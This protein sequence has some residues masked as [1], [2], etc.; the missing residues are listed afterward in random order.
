MSPFF[1]LPPYYYAE[2]FNYS[3]VIL[4][5]FLAFHLSRLSNDRLIRGNAGSPMPTTVLAILLILFFGFR[6]LHFMFGDMMNYWRDFSKRAHESAL[7]EGVFS[8]RDA[9]WIILGDLCRLLFAKASLKAQFGAVTFITALIQVGFTAWGCI[10]LDREHAYI[11]FLFA[12]SSMSYYAYA[13]NGMR[14]GLGCGILFL[15][16]SYINTDKKGRIKAVLLCLLAYSMHGSML[17]PAVALFLSYYFIKSPK[18]C[19]FFWLMSIPISLVAGNEI[20]SIFSSMGFDSRLSS[21]LQG[22]GAI[23]DIQSIASTLKSGFRWDFLLFSAVPVFLGW[24]IVMKRKIIDR[25]YIV[26]F[27]TYVISNAFW[28]MVI[29]AAFSNRFAQLSWFMYGLIIAYPL[30]NMRVFHSQGAKLGLIGILMAL[31]NVFV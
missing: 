16:F 3:I 21:Y 29:R 22:Y 5:V 1:G 23:E 28:I 14:T 26:L 27:N 15:A 8:G 11:L 20:S 6:P 30:V 9:G 19:I 18:W 4:M 12:L 24:Y 13:V 10:R 17:L 31:F 25:W 2:V 7:F